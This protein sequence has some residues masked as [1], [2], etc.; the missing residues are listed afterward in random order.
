MHASD[1]SSCKAYSALVESFIDEEEDVEA[2]FSMLK[3][4]MIEPL[5][6]GRTSRQL[7]GCTFFQGGGS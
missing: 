4:S 5:K 1:E 2:E 6:T 3:C 7:L